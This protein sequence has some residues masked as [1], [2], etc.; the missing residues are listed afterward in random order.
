M[1]KGASV[2]GIGVGEEEC[3]EV[4]ENAGVFTEAIPSDDSESTISI[5]SKSSASVH[6]GVSIITLG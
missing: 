3:R 6:P 4:L 2:S 5:D 1:I